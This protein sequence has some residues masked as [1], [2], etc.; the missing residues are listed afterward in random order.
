VLCRI[1]RASVKLT[2][3]VQTAT[4]RYRSTFVLFSVVTERRNRSRQ[5]KKPQRTP[6][7]CQRHRDVPVTYRVRASRY[8]HVN[9]H[10]R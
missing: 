3:H 2:M 8:T 5:K 6:L 9:D 1:P 10:R 4:G 7:R